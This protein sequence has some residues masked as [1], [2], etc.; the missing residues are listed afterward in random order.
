MQKLNCWEFKSCGREPGGANAGAMGVCPA[1]SQEPLE[2]A[3]HG[4]FAGRMCWVVAG[5][6]CQGKVQGM[7]GSKVL[8]CT[9]CDF[10]MSVKNEEGEEFKFLT[11]DHEY[12]QVHYILG[13]LEELARQREATIREL[14]TPVMEVKDSPASRAS[15]NWPISKINHGTSAG[16]PIM[17]AA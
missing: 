5:T 13:E 11:P 3:N 16:S 4:K 12:E 6:F 10:L 14:S 15:G 2:G 1:A 9:R 8:D 7:F 17:P